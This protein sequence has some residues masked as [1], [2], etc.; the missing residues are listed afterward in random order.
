MNKDHILLYIHD[1]PHV[2]MESLTVAVQVRYKTAAEFT[3]DG[4]AASSVSGVRR[5]IN[6]SRIGTQ[7]KK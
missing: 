5:P 4:L 3:L 7:N 6:S 2:G 1:D